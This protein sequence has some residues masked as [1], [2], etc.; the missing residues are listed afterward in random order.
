MLSVW[1]ANPKP[2]MLK[3]VAKKKTAN[4]NRNVPHGR[5]LQVSCDLE[6]F[7]VDKSFIVDTA[8]QTE[9]NINK[10]LVFEGANHLK[11]IL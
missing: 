2:G 11:A 9:N 6:G 1:P 8:N 7:D 4:R 3:G 10:T 5:L